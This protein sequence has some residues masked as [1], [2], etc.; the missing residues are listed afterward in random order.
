MMYSD[1]TGKFPYL[2][3]KGN[4]YIM[5]AYHTDANY[6]FQEAMK[7]RTESQMIKTY[8]II[9]ERMKNAGLSIKKHI[10]DNEISAE[11]KKAIKENGIKHELVP[12]GEHRQ[13]LAE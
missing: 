9:V 13:N 10:L 12:P 11:Y 6:I 1:Q 5:V 3:S 8:Q 4:R 2:S 7:N